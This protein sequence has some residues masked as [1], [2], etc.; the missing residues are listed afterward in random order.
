M[1]PFHCSHKTTQIQIQGSYPSFQWE[2]CLN[3][4]V[5]I[6]HETGDGIA[7]TVCLETYSLL[8]L[9]YVGKCGKSVS[10][11]KCSS[12]FSEVIFYLFL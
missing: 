11:L 12:L 9:S 8:Q 3:H 5:N 6:T 7:A 4:I 10:T 1:M 2:E